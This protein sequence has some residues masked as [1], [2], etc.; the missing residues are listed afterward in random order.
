M[1]IRAPED[2]AEWSVERSIC[3]A[4]DGSFSAVGQLLDYFREYLLGVANGELSS[5]LAQKVAPSDL[6]QETCFQATR[7][8]PRFGGRTENELKAWLRQILIHN[9]RDVQRRFRQAEKRECSRE[10]P[11][12]ESA[13]RL[14]GVASSEPTPSEIA[15][16]A[17]SKRAVAEALESLPRE[18]K[19]VVELRSFQNRPFEEVGR[20]I[21][22]S[23]E[24]A[25]K[26]W[27]RAIEELAEKVANHES[28]ERPA[29]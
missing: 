12:R 28:R 3:S 14:G 23:G 1:A 6:V 21:G 7:D 19:M 20:T 26:I 10:I 16:N 27:A 4:R 24:A 17:E 11:I 9:L 18:Q 13:G 2:K 15:I 25:R 22:K 8:F 5:D 29:P